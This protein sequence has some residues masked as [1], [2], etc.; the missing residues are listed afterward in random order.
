MIRTYEKTTTVKNLANANV[1]IY[2]YE[3]NKYKGNAG[4]KTEVIYTGLKSWSIVDGKDALEI[5][6]R[7]DGSFVDENHEYL[8]LN[9][10]DGTKATFRNSY[11]D[12]FIR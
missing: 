3:N 2:V 11:V 7:T 1:T 9:F 6:A 10:I 8:A 5:E 12:M 4:K